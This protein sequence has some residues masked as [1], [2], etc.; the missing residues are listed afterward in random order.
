MCDTETETNPCTCTVDPSVLEL[1]RDLAQ[2]LQTHHLGLTTTEP[3]AR[4]YYRDLTLID[5]AEDFLMVAQG[6]PQHWRV[7]SEPF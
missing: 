5:Q 4:T 7:T 3:F 2:A 6:K 1:I